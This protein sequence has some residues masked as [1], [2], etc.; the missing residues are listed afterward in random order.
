MTEIINYVPLGLS[1]ISIIIT[2][3]NLINS[4]GDKHDTEIKSI[5]SSINGLDKRI[6]LIE[7]RS[8]LLEKFNGE[9][10]NSVKHALE[11]IKR[12]L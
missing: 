11:E 4:R 8:E 3:I 5:E 2:A 7:N 12:Q 1:A 9:T 6:S 10:L